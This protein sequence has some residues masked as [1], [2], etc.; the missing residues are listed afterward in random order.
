MSQQFSIGRFGQK[1]LLR[2]PGRSLGGSATW[3]TLNNVNA[4]TSIYSSSNVGSYLYLFSGNIVTIGFGFTAIQM[5][6][7]A[8]LRHSG[9]PAG[10]DFLMFVDYGNAT[11]SG[12]YVA[13]SLSE[14]VPSAT[15]YTT[16]SLAHTGRLDGSGNEIAPGIHT[17]GLV[18]RNLVAGTLDMEAAGA[19]NTMNY[20]DTMEVSWKQANA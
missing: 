16:F 1:N 19:A 5:F 6:G 9:A 20:V 18:V 14:L 8:Q 4:G 11:G 13:Y 15:Y 17:V 12:V 10:I 3:T 2:T 7:Q